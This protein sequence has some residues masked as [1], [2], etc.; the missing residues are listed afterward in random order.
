M[1]SNWYEALIAQGHWG[2]ESQSEQKVFVVISNLE[3]QKGHLKLS[4]DLITEMKQKDSK[5][6]LNDKEEKREKNKE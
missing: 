5:K 6:I 2:G 1:K 3:V 4:K